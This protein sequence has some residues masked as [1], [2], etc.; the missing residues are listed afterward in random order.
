MRKSLY[1][2]VL[3]VFLYGMAAGGNTLSAQCSPGV[4]PA[5]RSSDFTTGVTNQSGTD[6]RW[7]VA[8]DSINGI[9]LPAVSLVML[10]LVYYNAPTWISF[11]P[12]GEHASNR[13]F[14]FKTEFDL[15]CFDSC[16]RSFN[17]PGTFCLGLDLYADNSIFEIYVNG[18][19][20]S[21]N[22]GHIIPLANPFNPP[23]HTESDKTTVNLCSNWKAGHNT[24]I[25]AVASSATVAG[26][27]VQ[28][29]VSPIPPPGADTLTASICQGETFPFAG[30]S[31]ADSGFYFHAFHLPTGCDSAVV[32][33]LLVKEKKYT[34]LDKQICA[35]QLFEGY[36]ASGTYTD[37]F[38]GYTG[39][40][41][42]RQ[43]NLTVQQLPHPQL[44][45]TA[46]WCEGDTLVL[47]PGDFASYLW[48]DG[49]AVNRYAVRQPGEYTVTVSNSCGTARATTHVTNGIC[50]EFFPSAFTPN[51]DGKNDIFRIVTNRQLARYHLWIFNRWGQQVFEST[52]PSRGWDGQLRGIHQPA[53][54]YVW[55]CQYTYKSL[56][57]RLKGTVMLVR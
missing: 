29:P 6:L 46:G 27:S 33:H 32:L 38:T 5:P 49:S 51:N 23:N 26:L 34:I 44:P 45:A 16:G 36:S 50:A 53:G 35:G 7:K 55:D 47:Q 42:I 41:S 15:P 43:L 18:L 9:Y 17:D 10:P 39:C 21:G 2:F 11:S 40:D 25:L 56:D 30:Q 24:L 52:D 31:L 8:K 37:T 54:V 20:Q 28:A 3:G 19:P 12:T 1:Y 14:F 22:L 13:F 4:G 57:K 48:Q